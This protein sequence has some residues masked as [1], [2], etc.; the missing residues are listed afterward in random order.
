MWQFDT[1]IYILLQS[2]NFLQDQKRQT[3]A[4]IKCAEVINKA[5]WRD[6]VNDS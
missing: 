1:N 6:S 2:K 4:K 5:V 3:E